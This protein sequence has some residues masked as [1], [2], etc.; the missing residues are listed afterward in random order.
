MPWIPSMTEVS[1]SSGSSCGSAG[2]SPS[3]ATT[4]SPRPVAL[5]CASLMMTLWQHLVTCSAC[6]D[7]WVSLGGVASRDRVASHPSIESTAICSRCAGEL[8]SILNSS[9]NLKLDQATLR[10]QEPLFPIPTGP[11]KVPSHSSKLATCRSR[12]KRS[13]R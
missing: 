12:P 10:L 13:R 9:Y 11:T 8:T 2:L 4:D 3:S 1:E 7:T 6:Y 5:S